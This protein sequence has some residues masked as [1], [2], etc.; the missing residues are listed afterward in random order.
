M[1]LVVAGRPREVRG[2]A[3]AGVDTIPCDTPAEALATLDSLGTDV[4]LLIVPQW[5][6]QAAGHRLARLQERKGPPVVLVLPPESRRADG[7]R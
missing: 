6:A 7:H 3:V 5:L 4:G 2:F 1:R